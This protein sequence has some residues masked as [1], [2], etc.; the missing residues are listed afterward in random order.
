MQIGIKG[1]DY[2]SRERAGLRRR[3]T[4][5]P[6]RRCLRDFPREGC[7]G[8]SGN[9]YGIL[10]GYDGS[11]GSEEAL[12]WAA[13]EARSR[14]ALLTVCQAWA[15]GYP[16]SATEVAASDLARRCGERILAQGL[17]S[18]RSVMGPVRCSRCWPVD[19]PL[20]Y[21]ASTAP[22]PR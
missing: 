11:A 21:F 9:G 18:A 3:S 12:T 5:L 15:A 13:R 4:L 10:A 17:R 14:R 2:G 6:V 22:A 8:V 20:R 19:Q 1:G 16:A 7:G